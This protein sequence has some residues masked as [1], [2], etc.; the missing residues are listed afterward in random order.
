MSKRIRPKHIGIQ[1]KHLINPMKH[2][3]E[4]AKDLDQ[5]SKTRVF[6]SMW[7]GI[8]PLK[9]FEKGFME[10]QNHLEK[11]KNLLKQK[12]EIP[13][14]LQKQLLASWSTG[15]G[16]PTK[17]KIEN[18]YYQS[19]LKELFENTEKKLFTKRNQEIIQELEQDL[20]KSEDNMQMD[21]AYKL[22]IL[23]KPKA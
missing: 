10:V 2:T 21:L 7:K 18:T 4:K 11:T 15:I 22:Q 14:K 3:I 8:G 1:K 20:K 13:R 16:I 12:K 6:Q 5:Q 23:K 19:I 9:G 17:Q